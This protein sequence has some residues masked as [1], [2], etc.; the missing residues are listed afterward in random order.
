MRARAIIPALLL[1]PAAL[2]A[3]TPRPRAITGAEFYTISFGAGLGTKTVSEFVV[4]LGVI[5]PVG[6]RL[7]L[8]AGTYVVSARREDEAGASS[9]IS[10]TTDVTLR[11]GY[12]VIP[13]AVALTLAV[14]LPT[15][16]YTLDTA[17]L[18]VANAAATDLIPFPV[19]NFGTGFNVTSGLAVAVPVKGWA[20][21]AAG[22]FRYNG[23]YEPLADTAG[24][25]LQPGAEYRLRLGA[26]RL[27]GQGRISLGVTLSTF[28]NDEVGVAQT[29]GGQRL[30]SQASLSFPVGN[31]NVSLF[32]WDIARSSD[33]TGGAINPP[34]SENTAVVGAVA[35][36]RTGRHTLRPS[37]EY[38]RTWRGRT[39]MPRYGSLFSVG[40][41]QVLQASDRWA[42]V[43][44]L[45]LD[46]G[47]IT[48]ISMTGFSA[49]V[50]IRATM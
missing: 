48:G 43:P 18:P 2:G 37:V 10:G 31:H 22:S 11:A 24:T 38:R 17:Q 28:S 47:N 42:I 29:G 46:L 40:A 5:V 20:L 6:Q 50:T 34:A 14:N 7:T 25:T 12:Q 32:A 15:G 1:I 49:G 39:T 26:D 4:P 23:E 16:Q 41:R 30:I 27:V 19:S 45:R 8:D 3:Q 44:S 36:V 21:G 9:T 35:S 33:S 13:D